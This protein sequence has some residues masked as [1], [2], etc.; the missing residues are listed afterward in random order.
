MLI[1]LP[2]RLHWSQVKWYGADCLCV[3]DRGGMCSVIVVVCLV[4]VALAGDEGVRCVE[5]QTAGVLWFG[6]LVAAS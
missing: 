2:A 1:C 5:G 6:R 4:L 3:S